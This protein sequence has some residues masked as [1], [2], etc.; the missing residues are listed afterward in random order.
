MA[1]RHKQKGANGNLFAEPLISQQLMKRVILIQRILPNGVFV[2]TILILFSLSS[3][4]IQQKPAESKVIPWHSA[5][6]SA[7][8]LTTWTLPH[9][10]ADKQ[11]HQ[12]KGKHKQC[13]VCCVIFN[14]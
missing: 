14:L 1:P 7:S 4:S 11:N 5:V 9:T 8:Q 12:W 2:I 3:I 10:V 6:I 13:K